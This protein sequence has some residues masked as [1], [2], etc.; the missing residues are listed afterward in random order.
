MN[1]NAVVRTAY[2]KDYYHP[3]EVYIRKASLTSELGNLYS[4]FLIL[5]LLTLPLGSALQK[6]VLNTGI[7][8]STRIEFI[9]SGCIL[10]HGALNLGVLFAAGGLEKIGMEFLEWALPCLSREFP[11]NLLFAYE[12]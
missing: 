1:N 7:R 4:F 3:K 11:L 12:S 9:P 8:K 2:R 6:P 5:V 10:M